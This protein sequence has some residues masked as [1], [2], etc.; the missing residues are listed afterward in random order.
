[1]EE[2]PSLSTPGKRRGWSRL[3]HHDVV[4]G[5][6]EALVSA[7]PLGHLLQLLHVVGFQL[8]GHEGLGRLH[9][10]DGGPR[11]MNSP[12]S[13][14]AWPC[15]QP[16]P[17]SFTLLPAVKLLPAPSHAWAPIIL[18]EAQGWWGWFKATLLTSDLGQSLPLPTLSSS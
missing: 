18:G 17:S 4:D 16:L 13:I 8:G 3:S 10:G 9:W 5:F 11:A 14:K 2:S 7:Q 12:P 1:M 15:P 6:P